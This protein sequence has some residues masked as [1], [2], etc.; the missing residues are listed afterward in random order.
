[1]FVKA[2][3]LH[4]GPKG[5]EL[6]EVKSSTEVKE[7]YIDDT[8]LQ[9]YVISGTGL[10]VSKASVVFIDNEYIR[11]GEIEVGKLFKIQD[12]TDEVKKRQKLVKQ[13]ISRLKKMLQEEMPD[14][15][16]GPHCKDPN[17]CDFKG[18]CWQHIPEYSVF[19]LGGKGLDKFDAYN[20]GIVL[21]EDLDVR[22][23]NRQQKIQAE[24]YLTK[25]EYIDRG[26]V[27]KFLDSLWYPICFF[28]FETVDSAIPVF[29][30]TKPYQKIP[31]QYSA[32][33]LKSK[34]GKLKHSEYLAHPGKDFLKELLLKLLEDIPQDSCVIAFNSPFEKQVLNNLAGWFPKYKGQ[35]SKIV[36][37]LRDLAKPFRSRSVYRHE[38][39][40]SYSL[41]AVLPALVPEMTYNDLAVRNGGMAMDAF[42]VMAGLK[43]KSEIKQLRKDLLEYCSLDTLAMVKILEKLRKI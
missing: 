38:M 10:K 6:Y 4:K 43:D 13:E 24:A 8:A 34:G 20:R 18:H 37:N 21:I 41:K 42:A 29:N 7:I 39:N 17:V 9:Y 36:N 11:N 31:F 16:I 15:D 33:L 19:K 26:N 23:L 1:V 12:I 27:K 30:G 5:W 3:I 35:I 25:T 32:H 40:G 28:D 22:G 2:D 14:I